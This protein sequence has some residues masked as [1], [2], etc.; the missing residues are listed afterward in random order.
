[1]GIAVN[2]SHVMAGGGARFLGLAGTGKTSLCQRAISSCQV[3]RGK[4][5]IAEATLTAGPGRHRRRACE[6]F[7]R[8]SWMAAVELRARGSD[9]WPP[10]T[11]NVEI[12]ATASS[13]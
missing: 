5:I 10:P 8:S 4:R 7:S 1:M 6:N 2:D 3:V 12:G 13:W 9:Q 11:L